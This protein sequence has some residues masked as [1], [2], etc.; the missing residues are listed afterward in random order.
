MH[1]SGGVPLE[2]GSTVR[3]FP[4]KFLKD[5]LLLIFVYADT[6]FDAFIRSRSKTFSN[7][8]LTHDTNTNSTSSDSFTISSLTVNS[9]RFHFHHR[10][11]ICVLHILWWRWITEHRLLRLR[12]YIGWSAKVWILSMFF[13]FMVIAK[14]TDLL[15]LAC[16][17]FCPLTLM[18]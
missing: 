10:K 16:V 11:W 4:R 7:F 13:S 3:S 2:I 6:T 9:D 5:T 8:A 18:Q 14:L 15:Y 17:F 1:S 12:L